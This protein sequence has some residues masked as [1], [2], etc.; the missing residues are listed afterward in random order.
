MLTSHPLQMTEDQYNVNALLW[1]SFPKLLKQL[2]NHGVLFLFYEE[3]NLSLHTILF[4]NLER[5]IK[6]N[7]Y[8]SCMGGKPFHYLPHN[9]CYL[10][11]RHQKTESVHGSHILLQVPNHPSWTELWQ[12]KHGKG[13]GLPLADANQEE[14]SRLVWQGQ[15]LCHCLSPKQAPNQSLTFTFSKWVQS[16]NHKLEDAIPHETVVEGGRTS[17]SL[18]TWL[19]LS[20]ETKEVVISQQLMASAL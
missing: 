1:T 12:I 6:E 16:V 19:S 15:S 17:T 11:Q 8:S 5:M 10:C 7:C 2:L 4:W 14:A 9:K 13:S 3:C 20:R 18:E